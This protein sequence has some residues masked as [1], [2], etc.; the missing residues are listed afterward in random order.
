MSNSTSAAATSMATPPAGPAPTRF[1]QR[2]RDLIDASPKT[3]R[4]IAHEVGYAK[5]NIITMF[6]QGD[7]RVPVDKI[8]PL[9]LSLDADAVELLHLWLPEYEPQ[10]LATIERHLG[11][12]LSPREQAWI[13]GLRR[14]FPEGLPSW[15][16]V[17]RPASAAA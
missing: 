4:Q 7:T 1:A 13:E 10:M 15:E 16:E 12:L 2:I 6:K 11:L 9:A 17:T 3:Q 5:P 8:G 14:R